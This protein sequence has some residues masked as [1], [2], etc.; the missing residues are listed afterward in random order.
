MCSC[1]CLYELGL[2][3]VNSVLKTSINCSNDKSS[4]PFSFLSVSWFSCLSFPLLFKKRYTQSHKLLY[5]AKLISW[6]CTA[7]PG[8][9]IMFLC[10]WMRLNIIQLLQ[11]GPNVGIR[12]LVVCKGF[13]V[14]EHSLSVSRFFFVLP[15]FFCSFLLLV[16]TEICFGFVLLFYAV[17][18]SNLENNN[19]HT[20]ITIY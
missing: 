5:A 16:D 17:G 6:S 2:Q 15:I 4:F 3:P 13:H 8:L 19:E 7:S 12:C 10:V 11:S 20:L 18:V 1:V 9:W 14:W